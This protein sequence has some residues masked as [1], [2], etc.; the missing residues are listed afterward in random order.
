MDQRGW[1]PAD[2]AKAANLS[3]QLVSQLLSDD[4][5]YIDAMPKRDTLRALAWAFRMDD[6]LIYRAAAAAFG[7]P[8]GNVT[9]PSPDQLSDEVL[10]AELARRLGLTASATRRLAVAASAPPKSERRR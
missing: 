3:P 5:E 4:R 7:V 2:L 6:A 8:V 9:A 10:V 1:R